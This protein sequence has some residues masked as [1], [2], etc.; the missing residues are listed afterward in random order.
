MNALARKAFS[1]GADWLF[2]L[3]AD[4]FIDVKS[5]KE[6]LELL[7]ACQ[8]D[9]IH[10]PWINLVPSHY[11][12][13]QVFDASQ[14]YSFDEHPSGVCKVAISTRYALINPDFCIEEGNHNVSKTLDGRPEKE[15]L[16][17]SILHLPVRSA[18]RLNYKT[19]N[20]ARLLDSKHNTGSNEGHHVATI[21]QRLE[22]NE[23][24]PALLDSIALTYAL[25]NEIGKDFVPTKGVK[26]SSEA[27]PS[28][29]KR[30]LPLL[31]RD[32]RLRLVEAR[33]LKETLERDAELQ[34]EHVRFAP[35]A[36]VCAELRGSD[37]RIRCLPKDGRGHA[38]YGR[39]SALGSDASNSP[40][41]LNVKVLTDA[42]AAAFG[43]GSAN[44]RSNGSGLNP[45]L[46]ALF[47]VLRPRRYVGLGIH[48]GTSFFAACQAETVSISKLS[49]LGSTPG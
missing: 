4:E 17:F 6:L 14:E 16:A 31:G 9:L 29:G 2:L 41:E 13:F 47:S 3:D 37:L 36:P 26:K 15:R 43:D 40:S 32:E 45:A 44:A 21:L 12:D 11:G 7:K 48:S 8:S 19:I 27:R 1:E 35:G 20:A 49:A 10:L 18:A 25:R 30:R 46:F 5:R 24:T 23:A 42:V 22:D 33:S 38:F 39:Y 34:W 28:L